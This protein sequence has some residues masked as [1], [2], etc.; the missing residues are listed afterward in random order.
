M[1]RPRTSLFGL[2]L[3]LFAAAFVGCQE[4]L[5]PVLPEWDVDVYIPFA[6]EKYTFEDILEENPTIIVIPG[7][8]GT[9][10]AMIRN[11]VFCDTIPI[12]LSEEQ[13]LKLLAVQE[14]HVVVQMENHLPASATVGLRFVDASFNT[15]FTPV[16]PSGE[17]FR[18]EAASIAE[19]GTVRAPVASTNELVV[20]REDILKILA[21]G[22][23]VIRIEVNT[24]G[25]LPVV[26]RLEDFLRVRAYARVEI[27]TDFPV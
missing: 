14:G 15:L 24:P 13:K 10:R 3:F 25:G 26:F 4:S 11:A 17:S 12:V 16:N 19:D 8:D 5:P 9:L 22:F 20:R 18:I 7:A 23:L 27:R 6:L 1:K 21:S 2:Y